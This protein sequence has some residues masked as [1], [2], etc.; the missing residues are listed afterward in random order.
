M[1]DDRTGV[2]FDGFG[3]VRFVGR[4]SV[5]VHSGSLVG[6]IGDVS[7]IPIGGVGHELDS[8]VGKSY[9]V[10]ALDIAGSIGSLL[11]VEGGLGVVISDGVGVGVGEDLVSVDL[12]L[13]GRGVAR[14]GRD[15]GKTDIKTKK[16]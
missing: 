2:D 15:C 11:S 10:G 5:R 13:V 9:R 6:H 14:A 4:D 1:L 8:T 12:S 16:N 7:I 3:N